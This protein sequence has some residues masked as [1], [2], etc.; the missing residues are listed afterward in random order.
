MTEY[1]PKIYT[2]NC[3]SWIGTLTNKSFK[4]E[5]PKCTVCNR[6]LL[7]EIEYSKI[8]L[9]VDKYNGEDMFSSK[10]AIIVTERL[11]NALKEHNIRG[12]APLKVSVTKFKYSDIDISIIPNLIYLA[13]LSPA[14]KNIPIAYDYTGI[15]EGC[16]M[17][18]SKYNEEKSDLIVRKNN[19]NEI[20][21]QAYFNSYEG[22]DIFNFADHGEIG[23]TQK[24]LDVIK[25]FNCPEN[26][27]IPAEW[28]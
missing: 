20:H 18:L 8:Q 2:L 27:V 6:D 28:I 11:Y 26:I 12:F 22:A 1:K 19:N 25:D 5:Q 4:V 9:E 3:K 21:L 17:Y 15:C 13:V 10:G 14:V 7:E 23:V 24:F 16:G